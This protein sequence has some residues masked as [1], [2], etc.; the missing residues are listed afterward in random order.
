MAAITHVH[1][2]RDA[3]AASSANSSLNAHHTDVVYV[4]R[5]TAPLAPTVAG[6]TQLSGWS[7]PR[8]LRFHLLAGERCFADLAAAPLSTWFGRYGSSA[9][10]H[11]RVVNATDAAL[12][13]KLSVLGRTWLRHTATLS[14]KTHSFTVPKV[15]L[16]ELL[17]DVDVAVTLDA[18]IVALA[19]VHSLAMHARRMA[20]ANPHLALVHAAEQQNRYRWSLNWTLVN[21]STWPST[22]RNGVNGG[23]GVQFLGRLRASVAYLD[24]LRRALAE[25]DGVLVG[26]LGDKHT[27]KMLGDQTVFR[28]VCGGNARPPRGSPAGP[29]PIDWRPAASIVRARAAA[30]R[31]CDRSLVGVCLP[32][33]ARELCSHPTHGGS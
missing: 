16:F 3:A 19:D 17:P 4:A 15:F 9:P 11:L 29:Q 33:A 10:K 7:E 1:S 22:R 27:A 32:A 14:D 6:I 30:E 20:D 12:A 31:L 18:D 2:T 5:G 21:G 8:L 23:V 26:G 24:V 25:L 13:E 28:C